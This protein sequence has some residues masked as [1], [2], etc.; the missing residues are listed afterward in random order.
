MITIQNIDLILTSLIIV[1]LYSL[2]ANRRSSLRFTENVDPILRK[3][4]GWRSIRSAILGSP[5]LFLLV[6][7]LLIVLAQSVT[8]YTYRKYGYFSIMDEGS[9][10]LQF[11]FNPETPKDALLYFYHNIGSYS[12]Q[13]L[14]LYTFYGTIIVAA[15]VLLLIYT[16]IKKDRFTGKE[17]AGITALFLMTLVL[18]LLAYSYMTW[19][20][21][22]SFEK[23]FPLF[24]FLEIPISSF[25]V[26]VL[27]GV[28]LRQMVA[29]F[30]GITIPFFRTLDESI[31]RSGPLFAVILVYNLLNLG[32]I[33]LLK[34]IANDPVLVFHKH[35]FLVL[36]LIL[37]I[38]VPV[39]LIRM[40]LFTGS[41]KNHIRLGVRFVVTHLHKIGK[42]ILLFFPVRIGL[43]FLGKVILSPTI[44][45]PVYALL[46]LFKNLLTF[47]IILLLSVSYTYVIYRASLSEDDQLDV[48]YTPEETEPTD[49][50]QEA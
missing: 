18:Y 33:V 46:N 25:T 37:G 36:K 23:F 15:P 32:G 22:Y 29:G 17:R 40:V 35:S 6:P 24:V 48:F 38:V 43:D 49:I 28:L 2:I 31:R 3:E 27:M 4:G 1:I 30:R 21:E 16:L 8:T 41:L 14:P 11:G 47:A 10:F 44:P 50:S 39:L 20:G 34:D 42:Y 7:I 26:S 45:W 19:T 12:E 13:L 5:V 9:F